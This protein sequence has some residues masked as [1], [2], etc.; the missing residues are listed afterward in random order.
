MADRARTTGVVHGLTIVIALLACVRALVAF[1][2][3][4]G[5]GLDPYTIA[6][7]AGA[8]GP[9]EAALLDVLTILLSGLVLL[10]AP[11]ARWKP[12]T[13]WAGALV[14]VGVIG[15]V[16][17]LPDGPRQADLSPA[18]AWLAALAGAGGLARGC[19][20]VQS[21]RVVAALL[22]G[23]TAMLVAKGLVQLLVEHP[24]TVAQFEADE[25]R[26]L[27]AQGLEPGSAGARAFERRL[28]QPEIT[29]WIGFSNVV[30]SFLAAGGVL[31]AAVAVSARRWAAVVAG[32]GALVALGLV[33]YG[34][35]KGAMAASALGLGCV[36]IG[37]FAPTRW[38]EGRMRA[39]LAGAI[40]FVVVI[41]PLLALV[42]RGMVGERVGELSL[43][44]RWFY[45]EASM[46]IAIDNPL[47]GVGPG[48]FKDAYAIA[49]NPISPENAASP[50][51][52]VFDAMASMG[53]VVG[54]VVLA[55]VVFAAWRAARAVLA[56]T[57]EAD[58]AGR[59]PRLALVAGP[60]IA[61]VIGARFELESVGGLTPG[62]AM[63]WV[64]GLAAWVA[65]AVAAWHAPVRAIALGAGAAALVLI[66]HGQIEMT[67]VLVGSASL[68][69]AWL[70]VAVARQDTEA[71]PARAA[72]LVGAVPAVPAVMALAVAVLALPGLWTWQ[73]A[74]ERAAAAARRP[75]EFTATLQASG[76][77]PRVVRAVAEQVSAEIGRPVG[78]ANL[79]A[80][81]GELGRQSSL[82]AASQ[83][84]RAVEV[85]PADG[86]TLRLASRAWLVVAMA[87]DRSAGERAL[88][89]SQMAT[90]SEPAS[91]QNFGYRATVL[92]ALHPDGSKTEEVLEALA[93]AE[94]LNPAS[95]QLRF[96]QFRI[97]REAGLDERALESATAALRA[98][99]RMRL[100]PLGAGLS[101]AQ[102]REI[103]GYL[104]AR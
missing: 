62:L 49:K 74:V 35:S 57:V 96:R 86:P 50:H 72:R 4:P 66:A 61:V 46:R 76:G 91:A 41:G 9:R 21:R 98:H 84:D 11:P 43:L 45:V 42:A 55:L 51:S 44:F 63:A 52:V 37:R 97:A 31:L 6:A 78:P 27:A 53:V 93:K 38:R 5:W 22:A 12:W 103:Q 58:D 2:P 89:L 80:G 90:E 73:T 18:L 95:P 30:A 94:A 87:V 24:S 69:A 102:V 1:D 68:W 82:A 77:D 85:A 99:E 19:A 54:V 36:A 25:A 34:G 104:G 56:S 20:D 60:A 47:L 67:P 39:R 29:G 32:V 15:C 28:R 75:A 83:A 79:G 17:G 64:G 65:I 59:V 33:V 8:F 10:L 26:M 88:A 101:E 70:A 71:A 81:L 92:A 13:G 16:H 7:P 48:G 100:D 3:V 14:L 23:L 40:A